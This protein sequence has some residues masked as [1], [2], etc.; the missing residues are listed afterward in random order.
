MKPTVAVL[1]DFKGLNLQHSS[2]L[3]DSELVDAQ[4]VVI[5]NQGTIV[6][7]PGCKMVGDLLVGGYSF[8]I[9]NYYNQTNS[10]SLVFVSEGFGSTGIK[11]FYKNAGVY[12]AGPSSSLSS[13]AE[14][15]VQY[16]NKVYIYSQS[17]DPVVYTSTGATTGTFAAVTSP[18]G[19]SVRASHA[20]THR[21]RVFYFNNADASESSRLRWTN[22]YATGVTF[23]DTTAYSAL[24]YID[25]GAGDGD[26]LVS[27]IE[28]SG[29]LLVFK[30]FSTW[31]VNTD[32]LSSSWSARK[33][34]DSVGCTGRDTPFLIENMVYFLAADGV[35][36]TDGTTFQHIS[37]DVDNAMVVPN[38]TFT[39]DVC[40]RASAVRWKDWY[41]IRKTYEFDK[42]AFVYGWKT[43]TWTLWNLPVKTGPLVVGTGTGPA[44]GASYPSG[45]GGGGGSLS[46]AAAVELTAVDYEYYGSGLNNSI[47]EI[48][49][50]YFSDDVFVGTKGSGSWVD[51]DIAIQL[52]TK[53]FDFGYP[54]DW[55]RL[56][57]VTLD[58]DESSNNTSNRTV[59]VT[60]NRNGLT[61][62]SS[63][64]QSDYRRAQ[65]RFRGPGLLRYVSL[66]INAA[67][68]YPFQIN[69]I[70]LALSSDGE[71]GKSV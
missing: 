48:S 43:K 64:T 70:G 36:R 11:T 15:A 14:T 20:I 60:F 58:T 26:F 17:Q 22:L 29:F 41:I 16:D 47:H 57:Y 8:P 39:Y 27:V 30:R 49:Q 37:D 10:S 66:K 59:T 18:A 24:N 46:S 12:V 4:N 6:K 56:H 71:V 69:A 45:V 13:T 35:Y 31:I 63:L 68:K 51:S 42:L 61:S 19:Y 55:K 2:E 28:L 21:F 9:L 5:S 40:N 52:E 62:S 34:H 23:G 38:A 50:L 3:E 44:G 1:K 67:S 25:I 65:W 33:V 32:G 7:R 53:F 54:F